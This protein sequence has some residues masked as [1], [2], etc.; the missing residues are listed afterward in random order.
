M[1]RSAQ[2][3]QIIQSELSFNGSGFLTRVT[4]KLDFFDFTRNFTI[5]SNS[6]Y[7]EIS[8][9][10]RCKQKVN[11]AGDYDFPAVRVPNHDAWY[12]VPQEELLHSVTAKFYR[13]NSKSSG[14]LVKY[15]DGFGL[16][17]GSGASGVG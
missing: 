4:G 14:K 2:A 5:Y 8:N 16:L 9:S 3:A 12:L 6:V 15:R 7:C 11:N 10:Q 17:Y 1:I 13:H